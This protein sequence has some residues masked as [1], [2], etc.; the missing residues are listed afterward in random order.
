MSI[1]LA[2]NLMSS[3]SPSS[4]GQR[5]KSVTKMIM[6]EALKRCATDK[7]LCNTHLLTYQLEAPSKKV[8]EGSTASK[9]IQSLL[10]LIGSGYIP[11][12]SSRTT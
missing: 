12:T 7:S 10:N 5:Q 4:D 9:G 11:I 2:F 6:A 3:E 8:L 1:L